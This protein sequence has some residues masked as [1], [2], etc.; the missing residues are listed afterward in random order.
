[1]IDAIEIFA[2]LE[3]SLRD[4]ILQYL[5]PEHALEV[6][7]GKKTSW[8]M[9]KKTWERVVRQIQLISCLGKIANCDLKRIYESKR[10]LDD[11]YDLSTSPI[12]VE[13]ENSSLDI[14]L[15]K[16][17][18]GKGV[19]VEYRFQK[20]FTDGILDE[21][22][23]DV[24][25]SRGGRPFETW[26]PFEVRFRK[27]DGSLSYFRWTLGGHYEQDNIEMMT[28]LPTF[29]VRES[30]EV[31]LVGTRGSFFFTEEKYREL[32]MNEDQPLELFLEISPEDNY[33]AHLFDETE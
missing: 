16:Y 15:F 2:N 9:T 1:M 33:D 25:M 11:L 21:E 30:E 31:T 27:D 12:T 5:G 13:Y 4:D 17:E 10:P 32:V 8:P 26:Y 29:T 23:V 22:A 14:S 20:H 19:T 28:G 6:I 24:R 7:F 18:S 3:Y